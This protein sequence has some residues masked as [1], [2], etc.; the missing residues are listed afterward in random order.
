M[1]FT[2]NQQVLVKALNTVSKAVSAKTTIPTLK[3]ILIE[4]EENSIILTASDL[5]ISIRKEIEAFVEEKGSAVVTAKLFNDIVRKLPNEELTVFDDESSITVKT[6]SSE[7][8]VIC[9]PVEEFPEV[10]KKDDEYE[11]LV[12]N[13]EMFASMIGRTAFSASIDESKGVLTGI[14]T[15]VSPG[16]ISMVAIDGFRLAYVKEEID[17][18]QEKNF[19]ISARIMNE[20]KKI[21]TDEDGEETI[22]I[23]F[24]KK[25]TTFEIGKTIVIIRLMEGEFINYQNLI[26]FESLTKIIAGRSLL[27]ESIERA[28]LLAREGKNNLIKISVVNNL[29]TITSKSEEG[30]VKEEIVVEKTGNDIEIGFNSKYIIDVL[31]A[32]DDDEVVFNFK[33]GTDPSIVTSVTGDEYKYLILPVRIASL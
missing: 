12:F 15:E 25:K 5:D 18:Q 19:I 20:I 22:V 8:R 33:T 11:S 16:K 21:I 27:L 3:G 30:N 28:S 23:S 10:G 17:G 9:M 14:L 6:T 4:A 13:K 7:F 29:M 31:K 24:G 2:C 1:K 26:A 32:I